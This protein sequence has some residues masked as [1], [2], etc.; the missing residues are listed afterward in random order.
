MTKMEVLALVAGGALPENISRE[1]TA[2]GISFQLDDAFRA[3]LTDAG[4]PDSVL[5]SL[6]QAKVAAKATPESDGEKKALSHM[7]SAGRLIKAKKYEEA[8][9]EL[10]GA[11]ETSNARAENGFVMG[12]IL[13]QMENFPQAAQ[14]FA[15]VLRLDADFPEAHTKAGFVLYRLD[16][17]EDAL[18]E[19]EQALSHDKN[20]A[21]AHKVAGLALGAMQKFDAAENELPKRCAL[22]PTMRWCT[23]TGEI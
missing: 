6:K 4:A 3:Q 16:D 19:A 9:N 11:L 8:A 20:N 21:E 23:S 10:N 14:V 7:A 22:N 17:Q 12:Q 15:E 5:A 13:R 18:G 2:R 1:I